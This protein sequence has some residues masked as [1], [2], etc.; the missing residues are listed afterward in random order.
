MANS[1]GAANL[2]EQ[3][4]S[5]AGTFVVLSGRNRVVL[6]TVSTQLNQT[7]AVTPRGL[8]PFAFNE[9]VAVPAA[10]AVVWFGVTITASAYDS[11]A[12]VALAGAFVALVGFYVAASALDVVPTVGDLV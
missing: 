7:L 5:N 9:T 4:T 6:G 10:V 12:A 2:T 3:I 11:N 8:T 1:A